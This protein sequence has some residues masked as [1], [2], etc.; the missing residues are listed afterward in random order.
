MLIV[1]FD[2]LILQTRVT[3]KK[4]Q[5][6][7]SGEASNSMHHGSSSEPKFWKYD[8]LDILGNIVE[9]NITTSALRLSLKGSFKDFAPSVLV[10][11]VNYAESVRFDVEK[12]DNLATKVLLYLSYIKA[13]N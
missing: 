1:E 7:M 11:F 13:Q 12:V 4:M 3:L 8:R 5:A 10:P 2:D 9:M 6:T